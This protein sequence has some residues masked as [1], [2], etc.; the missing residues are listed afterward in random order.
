LDASNFICI[1]QAYFNRGLS[2]VIF[3][4]L[5]IRFSWFTIVHKG[6][7]LVLLEPDCENFLYIEAL[8]WQA[9]LDDLNKIDDIWLCIDGSL[10]QMENTE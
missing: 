1:S 10:F 3:I 6:V 4:C 8:A 2:F 5:A 9:H 7:N